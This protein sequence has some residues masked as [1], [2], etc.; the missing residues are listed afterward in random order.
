MSGRLKSNSGGAV[1]AATPERGLG[2]DI[3]LFDPAAIAGAA[4]AADGSL[5]CETPGFKALDGAAGADQDCVDRVLA[6]AAPVTA[7]GLVA[8]DGRS[9]STALFVYAP[10]HAT[11]GWRLPPDLAEAATSHPTG[12][13]VLVGAIPT[14]GPLAAACAAFGLT[15]LQTRVVVETILRGGVRAAAVAAGVSYHTAREA[16][17][18]A[19]RRC[20]A[21][22]LPALV[23]TLVSASFGLLPRDE[24]S[25]VLQDLWGLSPR[26]AALAA[27]VAEGASRADAARALGIGEAVA[28]K[29]L[30][31][32]HLIL[33][34]PTGVVLG[35]KVS[36]AR[37]L[38]WLTAATGG[39]L[40]FVDPVMEPLRF[41]LGADGR[42]IAVSDYGPA[43][44]RAVLVAHSTTS[45][46]HV[47]RRL[48]RALQAAGYRPIAIDRPGFGLTDELAGARPGD[49]DP[50]ALAADDA[51]RVFD[52]LRISRLDVVARGAAQYITAIERR[53]PGRLRRVV[54]VNPD[55]PVG[56]SGSGLGSSSITKAMFHRNPDFVR[57]IAPLFTRNATIEQVAAKLARG[58]RGSPPD[59]AAVADPELVRD[60][61]RALRPFATG[62]HAGWI[63]ETTAFLRPDEGPPLSGLTDWRIL[64]GAH[65]FLHDPPTVAAWWRRRLPDT[66]L[67]LVPD[68]GRY[69]AISRPELVV[70]ALTGA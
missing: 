47:A 63:N 57:R 56:E 45:C 40:G 38:R 6:G 33:D 20:H 3:P 12:V 28:R 36:E 59:E 65:D 13:V 4:Y 32:V 60:Y 10:A 27:L 49:H 18:E 37:A 70:D 61:F 2:G 11:A 21:S 8:T 7:P 26:Q 68:A 16:I 31:R 66:P 51:L 23:S 50:F 41:V 64:V 14:S 67:R 5:V 55:P 24:P 25:E 39:D 48:L 52:A 17:A 35:R 44:G 46:R 15:G 9:E 19:E 1:A 53:A 34:A 43:S 62:R 30:E 29:E 58:A 54:L 69:L 22:R 42:R